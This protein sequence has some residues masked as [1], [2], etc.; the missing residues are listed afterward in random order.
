MFSPTAPSLLPARLGMCENIGEETGNEL[1]HFQPFRSMWTV[2][3]G[4]NTPSVDANV[5]Y[6]GLSGISVKGN[7]VD[8]T[9]EVEFTGFATLFVLP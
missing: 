8:M 1:L 2:E 9:L 3:Q 7:S 4:P 5:F 6:P